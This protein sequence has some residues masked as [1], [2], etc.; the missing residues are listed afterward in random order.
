MF[1]GGVADRLGFDRPAFCIL[2]SV[3]LCCRYPR[4]RIGKRYNRSLVVSDIYK[5]CPSSFESR[6]K[7]G[8]VGGVRY[9]YHRADRRWIGFVDWFGFS[10]AVVSA[11][12]LADTVY[13]RWIGYVAA[14]L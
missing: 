13:S 9:V 2:F 8:Q 11:Y 4:C 7:R 14:S 6:G 5:Y 12:G 1:I 3:G 10:S